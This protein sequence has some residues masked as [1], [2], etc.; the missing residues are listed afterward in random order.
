MSP[1]SYQAALPRNLDA[2]IAPLGSRIKAL[3]RLG[4]N[5]HPIAAQA[6]LNGPKSGLHARLGPWQPILNAI[7]FDD[8]N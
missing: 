2:S 8:K 1:T 3:S 7:F 5:R 4:I 6:G